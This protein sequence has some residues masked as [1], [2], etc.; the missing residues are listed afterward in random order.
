MEV[1]F[2]SLYSGSLFLLLTSVAP[3][4]LRTKQHKDLAGSFYGRILR[5]FYKIAFFLLLVYLILGEKWTGVLLLFGLGLNT[6]TSMWLRKY[7]R[8]LGSIENYDF[9]S[10]ERV[11]FRKVSYLSTFLL[12]VNFLL[13]ITVLLRRFHG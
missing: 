4:L 1:V 5:R 2:L 3:I 11:L 9:N 6:A 13:S 12:F 8:R 7:K 10:P